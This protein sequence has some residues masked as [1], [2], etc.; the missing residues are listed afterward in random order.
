[1]RCTLSPFPEVLAPFYFVL[2]FLL[3]KIGVM[4][5]QIAGS[6]QYVDLNPEACLSDMKRGKNKIE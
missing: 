1:M 4:Q 2:T 6:Y 5:Y 3:E